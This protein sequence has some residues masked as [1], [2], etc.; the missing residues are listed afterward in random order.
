MIEIHQP[1][2][3][4]NF[5]ISYQQTEQTESTGILE[6]NVG[7]QFIDNFTKC[8][9]KTVPSWPNCHTFI[10]SLQKAQY[11]KIEIQ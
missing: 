4:S 2:C 5:A 11:L 9:Y 10:I 1:L 7:L 3:F 6:Q 8:Q